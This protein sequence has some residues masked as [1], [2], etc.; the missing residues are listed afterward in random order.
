[1]K[2]Q[3]D[4]VI[5]FLLEKLKE[6]REEMNFLDSYTVEKQR[7]YFISKFSK[8]VLLSMNPKE[9]LTSLMYLGNPESMVYHL[10]FKNDDDFTNSY[11]GSISG[12]SSG[13]YTIFNSNKYN[14][15][16]KW[17][18]GSQVPISDE[19]AENLAYEICQKLISIHEMI[20]NSPHKTLEDVRN[21]INKLEAVDEI[22]DFY[23]YGWVH[24][25]FHLH[26]PNKISMYHSGQVLKSLLVKIKHH[27]G[28]MVQK[29]EERNAYLLDHFFIDI[30]DSLGISQVN[31]SLLIED[32]TSLCSTT[33]F[34]VDLSQYNY[35]S[36]IVCWTPKS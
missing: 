12:G 21:M 6:A 11:F 10:E 23:Q 20:E 14:Q 4:S 25:Y 27:F 5:S 32:I 33:Y 29:N 17:E 8:E 31:L 19:V 3:A 36:S 2:N 9:C 22:K 13:K 15:W 24:K 16:V 35:G 30:A 7:N 18:K 1:M 28:K 34:R 26:Y